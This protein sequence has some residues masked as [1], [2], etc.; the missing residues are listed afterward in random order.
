MAT[1]NERINELYEEARDRDY[2]VGRKRFAEMI[3]A[4][5]GQL[6]GWL[7]NEVSPNIEVIKKVAKNAGVS[8]LW[9]IGES[10]EREYPPFQMTGLSPKEEED[11]NFLLEFLRF[12]H[13]RKTQKK[14]KI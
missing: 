12:R 14:R 13:R 2:R 11:Y 4:T 1:F 5:G 8:V 9:L 3:G 10:D 6:D 7:D